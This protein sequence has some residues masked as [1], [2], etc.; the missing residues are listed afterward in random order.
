MSEFLDLL[1]N[2]AHWGFEAVTDI[3][4]GVVASFAV[5]PLIRRHDRKHHEGHTTHE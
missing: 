3:A 5:R 4:F 1:G 2:P